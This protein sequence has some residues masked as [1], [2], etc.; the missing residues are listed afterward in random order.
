MPTAGLILLAGGLV[1]LVALVVA[2]RRG[3]G[4]GLTLLGA[5]VAGMIAMMCGAFLGVQLH[6]DIGIA[7][8]RAQRICGSTSTP[9]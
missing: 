6:S 3:S 1:L 8:A 5:G 2:R 4:T 7:H 9:T